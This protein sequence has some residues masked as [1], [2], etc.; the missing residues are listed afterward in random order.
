MEF[1]IPWF[2]LFHPIKTPSTHS[3]SLKDCVSSVVLIKQTILRLEMPAFLYFC[4][5]SINPDLTLPPPKAQLGRRGSSWKRGWKEYK[6][7][8]QWTITRKQW[9][10]GPV[11]SWQ[12]GQHAQDLP[13]LKQPW[14]GKLGIESCPSSG[15]TDS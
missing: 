3:E 11:D 8:R 1:S 10:P 9:F 4:V 13:I 5:I 6:R 2:P 7:Q 12:L 15:A 14:R